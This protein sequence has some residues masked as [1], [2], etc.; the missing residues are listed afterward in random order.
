MNSFGS[1]GDNGD[2]DSVNVAVDERTEAPNR[3]YKPPLTTTEPTPEPTIKTPAEL[4]KDQEKIDELRR[5]RKRSRDG[6]EGL[7]PTETA[8]SNL[9]KLASE[10]F[11]AAH[12][13][14]R[15]EGFYDTMIS[16]YATQKSH[17]APGIKVANFFTSLVGAKMPQIKSIDD[18]LNAVQSV[19]DTPQYEAMHAPVVQEATEGY[20]RSAEDRVAYAGR[21]RREQSARREGLMSELN[22]R[23][24][25]ARTTANN[26]KYLEGQADEAR[27]AIT[28]IETELAGVDKDRLTGMEK[29]AY[30][31]K[32]MTLGM[33]RDTLR[34]SEEEATEASIEL[35]T[36]DAELIGFNAQSKIAEAFEA[37][38]TKAHSSVR[39]NVARLRQY[40]KSGSDVGYIALVEAMGQLVHG[41]KGVAALLGAYDRFT[42]TSFNETPNVDIEV[43]DPDLSNVIDAAGQAGK[44]A[45]KD[46]VAKYA[47]V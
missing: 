19:K 30:R 36:L 16:H 17:I 27:T 18:K 28:K 37:K 3:F 39:A 22:G 38:F 25:Q 24:T 5:S 42:R 1:E 47:T 14:L 21:L 34:S 7:T 29:E 10:R 41:N 31:T 20:L 9:E 12:E 40:L 23:K 45:R 26:I 4:K 6:N 35:E 43:L 15:Q 44:Q 8:T 11:C 33:Y 2:G 13:M 46:L 32:E